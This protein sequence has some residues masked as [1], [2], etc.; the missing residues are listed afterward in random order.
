VYKLSLKHIQILDIKK[1]KVNCTLV[2]AL[3]LCT[4]PTAHWGSR[5]IYIYILF[6]DH[7]T[8]RGWGVSVT[9]RPLFTPGK[10]PV[11]IVR[12]VGGPQGRSG[13][14]RKNSFPLGFDPRTVQPVDSWY[15]DYATRPTLDVKKYNKM[16]TYYIQCRLNIP[17]SWYSLWYSYNRGP[18]VA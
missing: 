5:G 7:G 2:Q 13:Q 16:S 11:P 6:H 17:Y 12:E 9:P 4:G 18:G 3:R 10:D 1:V 8:R 15:T 14:V